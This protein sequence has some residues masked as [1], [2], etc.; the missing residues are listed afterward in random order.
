MLFLG[1]TAS[2]KIYFRSTAQKVELAS[3]KEMKFTNSPSSV[4]RYLWEPE[5]V[6]TNDN[7]GRG[8]EDGFILWSTLW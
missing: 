3:S 1:L 7:P 4:P 2:P 8:L 5:P 6:F